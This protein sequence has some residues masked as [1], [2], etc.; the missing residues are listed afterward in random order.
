MDGSMNVWINKYNSKLGVL[1]EE[2]IFLLLRRVFCIAIIDVVGKLLLLLIGWEG[3][4]YLLLLLELLIS[5]LELL[6]VLHESA[7]TLIRAFKS[8]LGINSLLTII[9]TIIVVRIT[10][11]KDLDSWRI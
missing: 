10:L 4:S 5:L 9:N 7:I 2:E 11:F 1:V 8:I 3:G 6:L